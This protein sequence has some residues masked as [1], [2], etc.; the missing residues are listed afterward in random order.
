MECCGVWG[1]LNR[2]AAV[3]RLQAPGESMTGG[4]SNGHQSAALHDCMT[5]W[6]S[7]VCCHA[8]NAGWLCG[9]RIL[10]LLEHML[11]EAGSSNCPHEL[12]FNI[13]V[14]RE[15]VPWSSVH[16][17]GYR[18][19]GLMSTTREWSGERDQV[20]WC[21]TFWKC[22]FSAFSKLSSTSLSWG[23]DTLYLIKDFKKI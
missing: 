12:T 23:D 5:A 14:P 19:S 16:H 3:R 2:P 20:T 15:I 13:H 6:L 7:G 18:R 21:I 9:P 10:T 17:F 4:C 11:H 1:V 8:A 22:K